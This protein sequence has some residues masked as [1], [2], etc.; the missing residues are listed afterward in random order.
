MLN[1]CKCK[2][3]GVKNRCEIILEQS[4]TKVGLKVSGL[5][6]CRPRR[7]G[8]SAIIIRL[9]YPNDLTK[10]LE[11]SSSFSSFQAY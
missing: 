11:T 5:C 6:L 9:I 7:R 4:L 10:M 8:S 1:I 3:G 2:G